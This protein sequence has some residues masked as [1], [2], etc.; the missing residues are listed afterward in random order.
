MQNLDII[1]HRLKEDGYVVI[2]NVVD[3]DIHKSFIQDIKNYISSTPRVEGKKIVID[4]IELPLTRDQVKNLK[5]RW[6][7][8]ATF[9]APCE[10]NAFQ[11]NTANKIREDPRLY[12][13]YKDLLNCDELLYY[14]DRVCIKLPGQGETEFIHIDADPHYR[15]P[16]N[17][18]PLQS[19]MFFQDTKFYCIP[20]SH[21]QEFHNQITENYSYIDKKKKARNMT[22]IDKK[23]DY[24]NLEEKI[25]A[26]DI[27]KDSLLIFTENLWHA[28]KPNKSNHIRLGLYFGYHRY[29]QCPNSINDR[30]RSYTTGRRPEKFP[31][32]AKTYLV[33]KMYYNFPNSPNLMLKY[34]KLVPQQYHG[35]HTV[36]KTNE[37]VPWLNEELWDPITT[38]SYT[39]YNHTTLGK[40]LLGLL[41][42]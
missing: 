2:N 32:G 13:L 35:T 14:Q 29:H 20:K 10:F 21:T 22:M 23:R 27:P 19:I 37:E 4:D 36:K 38:H 30:I 31:S 33:P 16:D 26:I 40:K 41:P 7:L 17:E 24:M 9:G 6:F 25:E 15:K 12:E 28:S 42:Y 39:P 3:E 18:A 1:K 11:I 8:H 34:L 5:D